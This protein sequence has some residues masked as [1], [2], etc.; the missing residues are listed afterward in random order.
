MLLMGE[1]KLTSCLSPS[2][3]MWRKSAL[4]SKPVRDSSPFVNIA[5]TAAGQAGA[6]LHTIAVFRPTRPTCIK[7]CG[8]GLNHDLVAKL[9]HR[10]LCA[11]KQTAH[12]TGYS[13]AALVVTEWHLWLLFFLGPLSFSKGAV[14]SPL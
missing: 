1:E 2:L 11:T 14:G 3:A 12:A 13:M 5:Y 9:L 7:T 8:G 6:V 10:A 4:L